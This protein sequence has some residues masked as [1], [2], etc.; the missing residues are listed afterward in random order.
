MHTQPRCS[1]TINGAT[2]LRR[3]RSTTQ[4]EERP[5]ARQRCSFIRILEHKGKHTKPN[6]NTYYISNFTFKLDSH[7][8]R[9]MAT[10][11]AATA[12]ALAVVAA[13]AA[14][15]TTTTHMQSQHGTFSFSFLLPLARLLRCFPVVL[16]I[17]FLHLLFV[18]ALHFQ[19]QFTGKHRN[20]Q[21]A[22][23]RCIHTHTHTHRHRN[24]H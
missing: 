13:I 12:A 7:M 10:A 23:Q 16:L 20:P 11:A 24:A 8:R 9:G 22:R 1:T 6:T 21:G 19:P 18:F 5:K 3:S 4:P 15:A 17:R 2:K 14:A